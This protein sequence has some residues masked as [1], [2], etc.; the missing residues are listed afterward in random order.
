MRP[1]RR[2]VPS[3]LVALEGRLVLSTIAPTPQAPAPA[4]TVTDAL[5][6]GQ[7]VTD[8]YTTTE[9]DGEVETNDQSTVMIKPDTNMVTQL[10]TLPGSSGTEK[11]VEIETLSSTG[12]SRQYTTTE[13]NGTVQTEQLT[14]TYDKTGSTRTGKIERP[15]GVVITFTG[16]TVTKGSKSTTTESFNESNGIKYKEDNVS[17][18]VGNL[19]TRN[20][21]TTTWADGSSQ[22]DKS[23]TT[24]VRTL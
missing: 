24:D 20:I 5:L 14:Y 3:T 11:T 2:F 13:P 18:N 8:L 17:I 1:P 10:I 15:D 23:T 4:E 7:T 16:K 9:Y 12:S 6:A 19:T 21:N 22:V